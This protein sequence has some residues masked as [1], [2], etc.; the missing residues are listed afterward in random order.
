MKKD[1]FTGKYCYWVFALV[2]IFIIASILTSETTGNNL[3]T[4]FFF[5][6]GGLCLWNYRACGRVHC[7]ITGFGFLGVGSLALLNILNAIDIAWDTI[8]W[9]FVAVLI[10]GYGLEF[11]YKRKKGTC[12]RK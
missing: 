5:L 2:A 3:W 4:I 9:I 10:A 8:W 7:I 12:Y 11:A 6:M 1:I